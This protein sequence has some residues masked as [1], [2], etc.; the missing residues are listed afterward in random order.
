MVDKMVTPKKNPL[1]DRKHIVYFDR[2]NLEQLKG[3]LLYYLKN[4][5][6]A[7]KIDKEGR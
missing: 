6:S 7:K 4:P 5:D 1:I 3:Q 2:D